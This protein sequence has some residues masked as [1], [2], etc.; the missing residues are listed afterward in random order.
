MSVGAWRSASIRASTA[1]TI[2]SAISRCAATA[3]A[4]RTITSP[5]R[6]PTTSRPPWRGPGKAPR[7]HRWRHPCSK[8]IRMPSNEEAEEYI[9][10]LID[11]QV[12][13]SELRPTVTGPE[14]IQGLVARLR[15][16]GAT[17]ARRPPGTGAAGA[18]GPRRGRPGGRAGAVSPH[19]RAARRTPRRGRSRPAV[20][21]GHGQ[22]REQTP[23]WGRRSS[24]RSHAGCRCCTAW[25][26]GRATIAWPGSGRPSSAAMK[27]GRS[28]W[29][30]PWTTRP[31]W[32]SIP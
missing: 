21:G 23:A 5:S 22:A 10:D 13:V 28:R 27:G 11:N 17:P 16:R 15:E 2:G 6:R 8:K 29:S 9:G 18:G 31:A 25:P 4:G 3:R 7:R 14:P 1:P 30:R 32:A 12:L 20:P 19:R 26:A 24:M